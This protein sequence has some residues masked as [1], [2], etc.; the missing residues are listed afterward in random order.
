M[1]ASVSHWLW[2][3]HGGEVWITS[4]VPLNE[5]APA[6]QGHFSGERHRYKLLTVIAHRRLK[7]DASVTNSLLNKN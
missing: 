3:P 2:A 7:I 1:P 6:T 5:A 4:Q